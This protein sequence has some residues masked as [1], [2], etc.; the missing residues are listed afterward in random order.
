MMA[1]APMTTPMT[2][3]IVCRISNQLTLK[4]NKSLNTPAIIICRA[5]NE[6][7]QNTHVPIITISA[8][9]R[10]AKGVLPKQSKKRDIVQILCPVTVVKQQPHRCIFYCTMI[11]LSF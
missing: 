1:N 9:N 2:T 8:A 3:N 5:L 6:V 11:Y 10:D 4:P 7:P